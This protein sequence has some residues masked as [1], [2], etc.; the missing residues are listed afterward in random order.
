MKNC[1][2]S[3][4]VIILIPIRNAHIITEESWHESSSGEELFPRIW[5]TL[6]YGFTKNVSSRRSGGMVD[7]EDSKSS[8]GNPL[9]VRVSPPVP[10]KNPRRYGKVQNVNKNRKMVKDDSPIPSFLSSFVRIHP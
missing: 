1:Y 4:K 7:A 10:H 6:Q 9:R 8:G 3:S 5:L 2:L